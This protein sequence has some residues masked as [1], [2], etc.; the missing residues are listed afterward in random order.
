MG[1]WRIT[2][3]GV[4]TSMLLDDPVRGLIGRGA[5]D[6]NTLNSHLLGLY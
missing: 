3:V 2:L 5:G 4:D 1:S 6:Q